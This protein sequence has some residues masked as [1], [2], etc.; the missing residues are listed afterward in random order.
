MALLDTIK[1]LLPSFLRGQKSSVSINVGTD[2]DPTEFDLTPYIPQQSL[3]RQ[4]EIASLRAGA[5]EAEVEAQQSIFN[6]VIEELAPSIAERGESIARS[7]EERSLAPLKES[8]AKQVQARRER[9]LTE[10]LSEAIG[11]ATIGGKIPKEI[12]RGFVE[13]IKKA[14]K[15]IPK[16]A[17]GIIGKYSPIT[18]QQTL[19][20]ATDIITTNLDDAIKLARTPGKA[21]AKSNAVAQLLIDKF[22]AEGRIQDAIDLVEITAAK[23]TEQGQAIQALSLYNRLTPAGILQYAERQLSKAGKKLTPKLGEVLTKQAKKVAETVGERQKIIET[24]HLLGKIA[25]EIPPDIFQKIA[26]FQTMAQLLNPKTFMRNII[27]NIG[28]AGL[29]NVKDV[30]AAALD[31]A[32]SIVTGKR[33]KVLP[34]IIKQ[35]K[36]AKV[37]FAEGIEDALQGVDTSYIPTQ[38]DLPKTP[39]FKGAVGKVFD[40]LLNIEL[41]ATDR[42]FYKAA[43]DGSLYQQMKSAK[44]LEAT[45]EMKEIAHVDA[46]YRTFQDNNVIS[47]LFTKIKKALNLGK[48]FGIGDIVLKYPK[49]PGALLSRGIEYSPAGFVQSLFEAS[50]PLFGKPFNQKEFIESFS[51]ALT[52]TTGLVGMGA[53]LHRLGIITGKPEKDI[54]IRAVQRETGLGQ[55]RINVSALKRLVLSGFDTET[56]KLEKGDTLIS[57]DWFQPQAIPLSIG[58][59][60]DEGD[61]ITSSVGRVFEVLAQGINTLAEQ[62]LISGLTRVLKKEDVVSSLKE[63]LKGVPQ[64]FIPTVLSQINQLIDNTQRETYSPDVVQY[65]LNLA[66]NKIPGFAGSLPPRA[67]IW[68]EDMERYQG[69]SN[70]LFNVFFNPAFRSAYH[71]TEESEMVLDLFQQIGETKQAPR[72]VQRTQ[73]IN[74]ENVKLKANQITALQRYVG[75]V[76]KD[77]FASIA[78]DPNFNGL[79]PEEK[80]NYLSGILTDIG[81]AGKVIVLGHRPSKLSKRAQEIIQKFR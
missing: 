70:N 51:R 56:A 55:Y 47:N 65:A 63:I 27:G 42:A 49:T 54:D 52:G 59:N 78:A 4:A 61:G 23:A 75:R 20:E 17:E 19:A 29:E 7:I 79:S 46:L 71:P 58:A 35:L 32:L 5:A 8:F 1:N 33:T 44:V 40:K 72:V 28:F 31:S 76:S 60:I 64:S 74:G 11:F 24:A 66:K 68:G 53:I 10:V 36:G 13:T 16:V 21:T 73:K 39:V 38:F 6:R 48:N 9:P 41:K 15:T 18:N 50:R 14:P 26:H 43:Y 30:P 37:G 81:T 57:Y 69:E 25:D 67:S 2:N 62:P 77:V 45:D 34:S 80:V 12:S 22:Q 3:K